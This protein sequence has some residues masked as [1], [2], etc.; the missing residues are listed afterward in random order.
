MK[1]VIPV[2]ETFNSLKHYSV[3]DP[4]VLPILYLTCNDVDSCGK[5]F[6]MQQVTI[7]TLFDRGVKGAPPGL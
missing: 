1:G 3:K 7:D 4:L 2:D 6:L 5:Y